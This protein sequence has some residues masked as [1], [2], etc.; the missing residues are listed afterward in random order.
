[1]PGMPSS[2]LLAPDRWGPQGH[3]PGQCCCLQGRNGT[4]RLRVQGWRLDWSGKAAVQLMSVSDLHC[5][6]HLP[7]HHNTAHLLKSGPTDVC[8]VT[9]PASIPAA[10]RLD[11]GS[12]LQQKGHDICNP[13]KAG[14]LVQAYQSAWRSSSHSLLGSLQPRERPGTTP[15]CLLRVGSATLICTAAAVACV[16]PY[17]I[18]DALK[19]SVQRL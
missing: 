13:P 4:G 12:G 2:N 18:C 7:A 8:K 10:I 14:L 17:C 16:T 11:A 1:M 19:K 15:P 5:Q 3:Q 9:P 6:N